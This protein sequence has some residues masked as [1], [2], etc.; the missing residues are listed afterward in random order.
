MKKTMVVFG[1]AAILSLL[2]ATMIWGKE[3]HP[4]KGQFVSENET[5]IREFLKAWSR[6]DPK[7]LA[8]YFTDDGIY[9]NMP[10]QP[11]QG[12]EKIQTFIGGFMSSW[13]KTDWEV[14][15][16]VA[17]GDLVIAE[18]VD[19]TKAGDKSVDLPCVG[20]FELENGKIKVFR[21]Y[22]DLG[23]YIKAMS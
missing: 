3:D 19:R 4:R 13:T 2:A 7:E 21:D 9:H 14:I 8:S 23:T 1:A 16:I 10:L 11:V 17:A 5:V 22:F 20:V 6:L 15:N 12:R 18:R